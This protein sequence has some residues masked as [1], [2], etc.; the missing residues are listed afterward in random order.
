MLPAVGMRLFQLLFNYPPAELQQA[1]RRLQS[2]YPLSAVF[3]L[4]VGLAYGDWTGTGRVR[5]LSVGGLGIDFE[6]MPGFASGVT[7][8]AALALDGHEF[9]V[10]GLVRHVRPER[11][12]LLCG[13]S[14]DHERHDTRHAFLQLLIPVAAGC[15]LRA[16]PADRIQQNEPGLRKVVYGEDTTRLTVWEP[17]AGGAPGSFEFM[18]GTHLVR[19]QRG[20][21]MKTFSR[22]DALSP[23]RSDDFTPNDPD[24]AL[25]RE[26]RRLCRW[27]VL[28]L[29]DNVA[30]AHRD[31]LVAQAAS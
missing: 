16:L 1:E 27:T 5:D 21:R 18:L 9:I 26:I 7:V 14:I 15:S 20:Q 23:H 28:N 6:R 29:Q 12:G 4:S 31:F 10:E 13:L 17:A 2:R 19:G 25:D 11:G 30:A 24:G 22:A 3:P 8:R